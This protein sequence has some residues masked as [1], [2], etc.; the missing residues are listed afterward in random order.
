MKGSISIDEGA[1]KALLSEKPTSLLPVGITKITGSFEKGDLIRILDKTGKPLGIGK[2]QYNSGKALELKGKKNQ[3]P[4][5]M[6]TH[7]LF[8]HAASHRARGTFFRQNFPD[9]RLATR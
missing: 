7:S 4:L 2:T 3:K 6:H 5:A 8:A 9:P 1:R